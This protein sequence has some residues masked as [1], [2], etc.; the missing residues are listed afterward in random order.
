MDSSR[1]FYHANVYITAT[2]AIS[3][4]FDSAS[5]R[6]KSLQ[7]IDFIGARGRGRTGTN[8]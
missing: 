1:F 4:I 2:R 5:K 6:N 3:K 7:L 8:R